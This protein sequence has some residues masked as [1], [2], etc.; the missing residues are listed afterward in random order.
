MIWK[1]VRWA[2]SYCMEVKDKPRAIN[3][4]GNPIL[5]KIWK[6]LLAH[7]ILFNSLKTSK[8][9]INKDSFPW[10]HVYGNQN[11]NSRMSW[12]GHKIL[13]IPIPFLFLGITHETE[14]LYLHRLLVIFLMLDTYAIQKETWL[15]T[16]IGWHAI[17]KRVT[18]HIMFHSIVISSKQTC[19]YM[20]KACTHYETQ[21]TLYIP[22]NFK[23]GKIY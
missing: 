17:V 13:W 4:H 5:F 7:S 20:A 18:T 23:L 10:V 11:W 2:S 3:V 21:S 12:F 22:G 16:K 1:L 19:M 8:E 9:K 14:V 6:S 15:Q